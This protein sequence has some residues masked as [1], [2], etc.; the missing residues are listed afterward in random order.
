MEDLR[1][2][3]VQG[4]T[5]WQDPAANRGMYAAMLRPLAGASDLVLLPETFTSGFSNEAVDRAEGMDGPSVAWI[6][7]QAVALGAVVA[8]SVQIREGDSVFNRL[9]WATPDGGLQHYDKR[10]LFRMAKA[11]STLAESLYMELYSACPK[12]GDQVNPA[13]A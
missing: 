6:R 5:V 7:E 13:K 3:L 2:S 12:D 1:V 8:G 9:L 11:L 10:H 4:D